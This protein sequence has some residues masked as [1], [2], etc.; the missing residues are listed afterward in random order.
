MFG[1]LDE[2][3]LDPRFEIAQAKRP[4][5]GAGRSVA[6]IVR[7][8]DGRLRNDEMQLHIRHSAPVELD[9]RPDRVGLNRSAVRGCERIE[10]VMPEVYRF[11]I[12]GLKRRTCTRRG[13]ECQQ[14][15]QKD[16]NFC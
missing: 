1:F 13:A 16:R 2:P 9:C 15:R 11:G 6:G 12:V 4:G 7:R 8:K 3:V 5:P 14:G 10:L